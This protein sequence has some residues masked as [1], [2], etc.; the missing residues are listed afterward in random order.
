MNI[1]ELLDTAYPF[2][3]Y[4]NGE[5]IYTDFE[6]SDGSLVEVDFT[7][8]MQ[9]TMF[10]TVIFSRDGDYNLTG[11]KDALRIFSTIIKIMNEFV[12]TYKPDYLAFTADKGEKSR[13][14]FYDKLIKRFISKS[15][16]VQLRDFTEVTSES[17]RYWF[18]RIEEQGSNKPTL[19]IRKDLIK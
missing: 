6:L 8:Q 7:S 5:V 1:N 13:V 16:Y 3:F 19:L 2:K 10:Y 9:K 15:D 12:K 14:S 4:H 18:K 11:G 17:V